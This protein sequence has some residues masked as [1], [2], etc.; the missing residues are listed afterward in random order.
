MVVTR[1]SAS[2]FDGI[3]AK[4]SSFA[5]LLHTYASP[6]PSAASFD[7]VNRPAQQVRPGAMANLT[8]RLPSIGGRCAS[9]VCRDASEETDQPSRVAWHTS[10]LEI[11]SD[12]QGK[13]SRRPIAIN[14]TNVTVM[15]FEATRSTEHQT[16]NAP[17]ATMSGTISERSRRA[18][19]P[20]DGRFH[21]EQVAFDDLQSEPLRKAVLELR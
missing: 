13:P 6:R 20:A 11:V 2:H 7:G 12:G 14:G 4:A 1:G 3:R 5:L 21:V 16:V 18:T 19:Q 15:A 17:A 10:N 8:N 9:C